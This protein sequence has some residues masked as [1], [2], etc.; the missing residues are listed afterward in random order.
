MRFG[1]EV[2]KT[3]RAVWPDDKP[4]GIRVSATD[5][6]PGGWTVE[7]T[8]A[9]AKE[10]DTLGCDYI[11]VSSGGLSADQVIETGP[12]YQTVFAEAVKRAVKMKVIT[13]GQITTP[14]QAETIL[15]TG[16]ADL[17]ALARVMLFNPR[18]PWIA[19]IELGAEPSFPRQ[20]QRADPRRW[21]QSGVSS[22]GNQVAR[23]A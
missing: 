8:I 5:W 9:F 19:A 17:V 2:F 1:L 22:P 3:V 12:G 13:V 7:E 20:Y 21:K 10:L 4:L 18:W 14:H 11:H 16:Q 15:R 23:T 6:T